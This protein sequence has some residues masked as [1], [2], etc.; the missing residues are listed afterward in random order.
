MAKTQDWDDQKAV[1]KNKLVTGQQPRLLKT[2]NNI[3]MK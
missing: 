2:K 1:K 3:W